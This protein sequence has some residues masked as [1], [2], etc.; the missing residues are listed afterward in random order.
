M[1]TTITSSVRPPSATVEE[2]L[3]R[4]ERQLAEAR[5]EIVRQTGVISRANL[6]CDHLGMR[7][8]EV[9]RERD[10]LRVALDKRPPAALG[11]PK[12]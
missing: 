11:E 8:G 9:I 5:A 12:P 4:T 7:L 6:R 3:Q 2:Q 10:A 1:N